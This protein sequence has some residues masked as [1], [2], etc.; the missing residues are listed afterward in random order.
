MFLDGLKDDPGSF[1]DLKL[2]QQPLFGEVLQVPELKY[3][4]DAGLLDQRQL[5]S[6]VHHLELHLAVLRRR[7]QEAQRV[8]Q[9]TVGMFPPC[10]EGHKGQNKKSN[11][12]HALSSN[13]TVL[14]DMAKQLLKGNLSR[15]VLGAATKLKKVRTR[16]WCILCIA[17]H[18]T[19][20]TFALL[21][22][23]PGFESYKRYCLYYQRQWLINVHR[24]H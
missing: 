7:E 20:V 2:L 21:P 14:G 13:T 6:G 4:S 17:L 10:D 9:A 11:L 16:G 23:L 22:L 8:G 15:L 5:G 3:F 19:E 1:S 18:S 12:R 24:T